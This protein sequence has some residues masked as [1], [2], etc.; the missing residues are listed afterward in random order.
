VVLVV[1]LL[2]VEWVNI[3]VVAEALAELKLIEHLELE[4][5]H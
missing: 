4:L 3:L 2:V 1:R 5:A